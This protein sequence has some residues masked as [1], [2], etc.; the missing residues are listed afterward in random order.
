[1]HACSACMHA[2]HPVPAKPAGVFTSTYP[3]PVDMHVAASQVRM[4]MQAVK[5]CRSAAQLPH[6]LLHPAG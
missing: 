2:V 6:F 4:Q 3:S 5:A 1:M